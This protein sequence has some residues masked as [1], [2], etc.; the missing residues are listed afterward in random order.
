V[1]SYLF[2]H[3]KHDEEIPKDKSNDDED[4]EKIFSK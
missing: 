1:L 3:Q 2:H 4:F